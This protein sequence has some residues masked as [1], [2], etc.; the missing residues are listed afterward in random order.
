MINN[1]LYSLA[2]DTDFVSPSPKNIK[3]QSWPPEKD[4]PIVVDKN[5]EVISKWEDSIWTLDLWAGKRCILNF[6]DSD[7]PSKS[8]PISKENAD[9]LRLVTGWWIYGSRRVKTAK[10]LLIRFSSLRPIFSSCSE[11]GIL[12]SELNKY[13]LVIDKIHENLMPSAI[14]LI[15][16]LLHEL[17]AY[18]EEIGFEI[19]NA[20][21]IAKVA[22]K[23][24]KHIT[25]QTPYIPPRIWD[26]QLSRL[27]ECLTDFINN[28][29]N[30]ELLFNECFN[31]FLS[32]KNLDGT[33]KKLNTFTVNS[34]SFD[35]LTDKYKV[36]EVIKKWVG[37]ESKFKRLKISK[38]SSYFTLMS[39]VSIGY[40]LNFTLMRSDEAVN[41]KKNC[42]K[43]EYDPNFGKIYLIE[44]ITSKTM[45]DNNTYWVTSE[46]TK[47]A[48][49]V[50][51]TISR[52][53]EKCINESND[54][55]LIESFEP[56]SSGES[57]KIN[58]NNR[59]KPLAYGNLIK[60]FPLLLDTEELKINKRDLELARLAN[61]TLD[62]SF[63]IGE[64]W[65]LAWHQLRRTGAVNMQASGMVSESS[66]QFQLKHLSRAMSLYYGQNHA[67]IHLEESSHNLYV[68][69]M[70]ESIG[71]Q[72]QD[73]VKNNFVSPYG[74][75]QKI[76]LVRLI[77]LEDFK[78][79]LQLAKK[80]GVACR[81]VV[82][83]MCMNKE[84]CPYGGIES[85]AHCG[86][87]DSGKPCSEILYDINKKKEVLKLDKILS[88]RLLLATEN[89]PL[90][91][92]IKAQ[93]LSVKNYLETIERMEN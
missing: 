44:G 47:L 65:P 66:L 81:E 52:L 69:E 13:P 28:K 78:K 2:I 71:K 77:S 83:G 58:K 38:L 21:N 26:Y 79:S 12:V 1:T 89:S 87:G 86:G 7:L 43:E 68:Q 75:K 82:L 35:D 17:L 36:K 90:S 63:N 10:T 48:I 85:I 42:L 39:W 15:V 34:N 4:F 46:S 62:N 30:I 24:E 70:Y 40:V 93:K 91:N 25:K 11:E 5:N 9:I 76:E 37:L 29:E 16:T 8:S 18:K 67:R 72:L 59:P 14:E 32:R 27:N 54:F 33:Y 73:T 49:E 60:R 23:F 80:G 3:L 74:E 64:I 88:D 45:K 55:L 53:R 51:S 50:L 57:M 31:A 19:L 56:W 84:P 92:S 41:L 61:P 20:N 22:A 6:G